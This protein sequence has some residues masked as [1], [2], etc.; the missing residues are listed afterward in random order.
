MSSRNAFLALGLLGQGM[1]AYGGYQQHK[2][3][4]LQQAQQQQAQQQ[5]WDAYIQAE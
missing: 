5:A 3:S 4:M 2:Q 1:Q